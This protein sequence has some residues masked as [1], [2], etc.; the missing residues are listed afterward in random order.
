MTSVT[1]VDDVTD[2]DMERMAADD[3]ILF[4]LM[5]GKE[6]VKRRMKDYRLSGYGSEGD[7]VNSRRSSSSSIS[8]LARA[9]GL[10]G[11]NR[12]YDVIDGRVVHVTSSPAIGRRRITVQSQLGQDQGQG[13]VQLTSY[14][15]T[16]APPNLM[17]SPVMLSQS[18]SDVRCF[19]TS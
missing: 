18:S 16:S 2:D 14:R 10:L 17:T 1:P 3:V 19:N 15:K 8:S 12:G 11:N 6:L 9:D 13:N 7:I 4:S 5:F